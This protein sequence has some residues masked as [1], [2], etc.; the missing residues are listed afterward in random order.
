MIIISL[1]IGYYYSV[2]LPRRDRQQTLTPKVLGEGEV[3]VVEDT[4]VEA[5]IN[6]PTVI[7]STPDP[8]AVNPTPINTPIPTPLTTDS[9]STAEPEIKTNPIIINRTVETTDWEAE[10]RAREAEE[11]QRKTTV[12]SKCVDDFNESMT[13]YAECQK[14]NNETIQ[15]YNDK[16][17]KYSECV[18]QYNGKLEEYNECMDPDSWRHSS[19]CYKPSNYCSKP[20]PVYS[21][22]CNKPA[23]WC[24]KPYCS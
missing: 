15:T 20:F 14:R 10:R 9:A 22:S 3:K 17:E 23:N 7:L 6:P 16:M 19:F 5:E 18:D 1:S 13:R 8:I 12:Y 4:P 21:S 11:C 24:T 2:S